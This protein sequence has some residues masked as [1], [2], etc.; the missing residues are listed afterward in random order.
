MCVKVV[1]ASKPPRCATNKAM[2]REML[3]VEPVRRSGYPVWHEYSC[4]CPCDMAATFASAG[5]SEFERSDI[6]D[7]YAMPNLNPTS[8]RAFDPERP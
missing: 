2:L 7:Y 1:I 8:P 5:V 4:L 6:G 3:G